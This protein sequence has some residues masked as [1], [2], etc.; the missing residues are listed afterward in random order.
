MSAPAEKTTLKPD[1]KWLDGD[2]VDDEVAF[3]REFDP[4]TTAAKDAREIV[5]KYA[6]EIKDAITK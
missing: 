6:Q 2:S 4:K 3:S 1:V 5:S